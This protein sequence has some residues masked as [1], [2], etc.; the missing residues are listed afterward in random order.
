M[1]PFR[2]L[3]VST[4]IPRRHGTRIFKPAEWMPW[5][6]LA[7]GAVVLLYALTLI[8][9]GVKGANRSSFLDPVLSA[10]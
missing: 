10:H 9:A 7:C 8:V 1:I 3:L 6:C 2:R 4:P 5:S